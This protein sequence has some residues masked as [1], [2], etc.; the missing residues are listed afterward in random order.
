[1]W[2]RQGNRPGSVE[3]AETRVGGEQ[4]RLLAKSMKMQVLTY[5]HGKSCTVCQ[6]FG[7]ALIL[8]FT[9]LYHEPTILIPFI[10]IPSYIPG[11]N[12]GWWGLSW[13]WTGYLIIMPEFTRKRPDVVK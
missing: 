10:T 5:A 13:L 8:E 3:G 9:M 4:N 11:M 12:L 6:G 2:T 1:M 7:I